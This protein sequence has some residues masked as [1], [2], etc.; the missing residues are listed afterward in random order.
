MDAEFGGWIMENT[1]HSVNRRPDSSGP[2]ALPPDALPAAPSLARPHGSRCIS[3][4]SSNPA[5]SLPLSRPWLQ[6]AAAVDDTA[7]K[8]LVSDGG[9]VLILGGRD[10]EIVESYCRRHPEVEPAVVVWLAVTTG[11]EEVERHI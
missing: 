1:Y 2:L 4:G 11:M 10:R 9:F 8:R 5:G 7:V 3:L 6:N